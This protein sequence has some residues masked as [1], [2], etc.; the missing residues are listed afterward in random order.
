MCYAIF[1]P[2]RCFEITQRD[3]FRGAIRTIAKGKKDTSHVLRECLKFSN[4]KSQV[5][6]CFERIDYFLG[7]PLRYLGGELWNYPSRL[8]PRQKFSEDKVVMTVVRFWNDF[9]LHVRRQLH[10][11]NILKRAQFAKST[12]A[13]TF[14]REFF[15]LFPA[16]Q[17]FNDPRQHCVR[18]KN[19]RA[20]FWFFSITSV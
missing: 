15:F 2:P 5:Y 9:T 13:I 3:N 10:H 11:D 7:G 20:S 1:F 12:A 6:G 16:R 14:T 19:K 17:S 4:A 8:L 18:E